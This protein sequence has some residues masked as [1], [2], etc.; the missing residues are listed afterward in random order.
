M[1]FFHSFVV[2]TDHFR[3][4]GDP[5]FPLEAGAEAVVEAEVFPNAV[6]PEFWASG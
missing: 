5:F 2:F 3:E 6:D 4:E 1:D